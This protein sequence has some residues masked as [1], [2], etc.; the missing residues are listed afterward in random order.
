MC[1]PP[2]P[3]TRSNE[4][5]IVAASAVSLSP[6]TVL[7]LYPTPL[8][9]VTKSTRMASATVSRAAALSHMVAAWSCVMQEKTAFRGRASWERSGEFGS[10]RRARQRAQNTARTKIQRD[11][12]LR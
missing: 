12:L 9:D 5:E 2:P 10:G 3:H 1:M 11:Q 4:S 6:S 7:S 8:T